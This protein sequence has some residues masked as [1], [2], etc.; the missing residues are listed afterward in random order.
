M[1][2]PLRSDEKVDSKLPVDAKDM[3]LPKTT[4]PFDFRLQ[5]AASVPR[6]TRIVLTGQDM[7]EPDPAS[8]A[9]IPRWVD[10]LRVS[11]CPPTMT[12]PAPAGTVRVRTSASADGAHAVTAPLDA[13]TE[14]SRDRAWLPTT[15]NAPTRYRVDPDTS[16]SL[17]WALTLAL[18]PL[19][20]APVVA[21]NAATRL[22]VV[23]LTEVK[24]PA[25]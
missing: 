15:V 24:S 18:K 4:D 8:S 22:R 5:M 12:L 25:T 3:P 10:P 23:P 11:K 1:R 9:P 20:T 13:L 17:T 14:A 19:M 21:F 6:L 2:L 16:R 7:V